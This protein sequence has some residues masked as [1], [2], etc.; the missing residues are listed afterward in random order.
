MYRKYWKLRVSVPNKIFV[1]KGKGST[2]SFV[3]YCNF[4]HDVVI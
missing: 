2:A 4:Y 1:V 3:A